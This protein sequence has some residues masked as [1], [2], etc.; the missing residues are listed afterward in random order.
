MVA[1]DEVH[2]DDILEGY[3]LYYRPTQRWYYVKDQLPTELV[4]FKA[5]DSIV[6]GAGKADL[7]NADLRCHLLMPVTSSSRIF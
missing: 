4:V 1:L 7:C 6:K 5:G 3:Q 2:K